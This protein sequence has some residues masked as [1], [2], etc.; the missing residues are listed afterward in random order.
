MEP[1]LLVAL[2]TT[3]H[4]PTNLFG[5]VA[6][7]RPM[8]QQRDGFANLRQRNRWGP[9]FSPAA[10]AASG[11]TWLTRTASDDDAIRSTCELHSRPSP[12]RFC[13]VSSIPRCDVPP[14]T[15]A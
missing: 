13:Y 7:E 8:Q 2:Q 15:H 5:F 4:V 12:L 14:S 6:V 9:V 10:F 11:T 3:S 1:S